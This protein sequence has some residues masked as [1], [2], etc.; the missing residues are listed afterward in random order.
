[1][2]I[3]SPAMCDG[4]TFLGFMSVIFARPSLLSGTIYKKLSEQQGVYY[5]G[6]QMDI[7]M[8]TNIYKLTGFN[9]IAE[10]KNLLSG[11]IS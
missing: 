11:T 8:P 7:T 6:R 9:S 5:S 1:M 4:I 2:L 3:F 10:N